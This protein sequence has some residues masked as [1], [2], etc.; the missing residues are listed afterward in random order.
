VRTDPEVAAAMGSRDRRS[1]D[2]LFILLFAP[3]LRSDPSRDRKR[4]GSE[5][6]PSHRQCTRK[7]NGSDTLGWIGRKNAKPEVGIYPCHRAPPASGELD[8]S[9]EQ[10]RSA[11][12][13][14][15]P[16]RLFIRLFVPPSRSDPSRDRNGVGSEGAPSHRQC[17]RKCNGS[18]TLGWIGRKNAK[19]EVGVY[20]C[21]RAPPASGELDLSIAPPSVSA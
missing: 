15:S 11:W 7:R 9:T 12:D 14:R 16:D 1:P 2:R 6:A 17:T 5:G 3:P 4:V 19:P 20:P 18:D 10:I 8:L 21:H 13:R